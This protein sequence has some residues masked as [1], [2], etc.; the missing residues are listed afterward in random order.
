[1][2]KYYIAY[3]SNLN[4]NQMAKRCH[5]AVFVGVG[6]MNNYELVFRGGR[7]SAVATV[8]SK[9]GSKVPVGLW[10][11]SDK[12]EKMLDRYEGFPKL[13]IKKEFMI[14]RGDVQKSAMIYVMN[15]GYDY[16]MPNKIYY[17]TIR[18]GYDDCH[19]DRKYLDDAVEKMLDHTEKM[20]IE[21]RY[22]LGY[23]D[24]RK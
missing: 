8:E 22:P 20:E 15:D 2:S 16:G 19:L 10:K 3:G 9:E 4:M 1:M 12:D 17:E 23:R 24:I 11:I 7:H 18:Q 5:D 14:S 21:E 13:Y 6:M